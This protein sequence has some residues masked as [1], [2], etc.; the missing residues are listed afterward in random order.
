VI[1]S[2]PSRGHGT[3]CSIIILEENNFK[4][5]SRRANVLGKPFTVL[6]ILS[7]AICVS[8]PFAWSG[9]RSNDT[10]LSDRFET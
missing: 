10:K 9:V 8:L 4:K 5:T 3:A 2:R 7:I 1:S 6:M